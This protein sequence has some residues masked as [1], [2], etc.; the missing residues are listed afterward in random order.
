[1]D[2]TGAIFLLVLGAL[3]IVFAVIAFVKPQWF[4]WRLQGRVVPAQT[5]GIVGLVVGVP[6][7]GWGIYLLVA[8]A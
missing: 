8:A 5:W 1:M 3:L 2:L 6:L 7:T 4:E